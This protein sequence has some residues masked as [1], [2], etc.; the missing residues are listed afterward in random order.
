MT[1]TYDFDTEYFELPFCNDLKPVS[2]ADQQLEHIIVYVRKCAKGY[3]VF[4]NEHKHF[5][6]SNSKHAKMLVEACE[7]YVDNKDDQAVLYYTLSASG[8]PKY[9]SELSSEAGKWIAD[10]TG[11][12]FMQCDWNTSSISEAGNVFL[13]KSAKGEAGI[14]TRAQEKPETGTPVTDKRKPKG[15]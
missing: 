7:Y 8:N 11:Y 3:M 10:I 5:L 9:G 4:S 15:V 2:Q 6:F 12:S 14:T 1:S 13:K